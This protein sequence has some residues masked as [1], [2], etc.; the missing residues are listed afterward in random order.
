MEASQ[1]GYGGGWNTTFSPDRMSYYI[2]MVSL[3]FDLFFYKASLA[4]YVC[5]SVV[6]VLYSKYLFGSWKENKKVADFFVFSQ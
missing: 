5:M 6:H 1:G 4:Q 2:D 3:V